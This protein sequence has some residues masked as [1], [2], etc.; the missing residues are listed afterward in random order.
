MSMIENAADR[1]NADFDA[2]ENRLVTDAE[3]DAVSGGLW[4]AAALALIGIGAAI[5]AGAHK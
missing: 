5:Y 4:P 1:V 3:L 2:T